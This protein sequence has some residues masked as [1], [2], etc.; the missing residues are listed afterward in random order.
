MAFIWIGESTIGGIGT[1]GGDALS[2]A[3]GR[4]QV[5]RDRHT[6]SYNACNYKLGDGKEPEDIHIK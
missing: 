5:H 6:L 3:Q 2:K 4:I 1:V